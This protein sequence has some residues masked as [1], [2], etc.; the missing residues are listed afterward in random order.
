MNSGTSRRLPA[1]FILAV[2]IACIGYTAMHL[3][4]RFDDLSARLE[5]AT[6]KLAILEKSVAVREQADPL[7]PVECS[8]EEGLGASADHPC[9]V[10]FESLRLSPQK[11]HGRWIAVRA[12]YISGFETSALLGYMPDAHR[13]IVE[14]RVPM[15]WVDADTDNSWPPRKMN[16]IGQFFNGPSG[17]MSACFG[18]LRTAKVI[19]DTERQ[20]R[21]RRQACAAGGACPR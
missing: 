15:V 13:N 12:L 21:E 4:R 5:A 8:D 2:A 1:L 17:H 18:R 11:F 19:P 6:G 9:F 3:S 16:F 14:Q 20:E 7:M 10:S